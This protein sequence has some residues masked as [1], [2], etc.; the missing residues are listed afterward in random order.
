MR[1]RVE[2]LQ[3]SDTED[4]KRT[5]DTRTGLV[6]EGEKSLRDVLKKK[7]TLNKV[8]NEIGESIIHNKVVIGRLFVQR[9]FLSWLNELNINPEDIL[10]KILIPDTVIFNPNLRTVY[11]VEMKTQNT[12]GSADEKLQTCVFKRGQFLR[13]FHPLKYRVEYIYLLSDWFK[14]ETYLDVRDYIYENGC[15]YHFDSIPVWW[16][17]FPT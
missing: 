2:L 14:K 11:V 4:K 1:K 7:Y 8:E 5:R 13:L 16:F 15:S 17:G 3:P 6:F 9:E 12:P 10:S